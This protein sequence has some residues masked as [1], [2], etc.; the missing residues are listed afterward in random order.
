MPPDPLIAAYEGFYRTGE[1]TR[2]ALALSELM[3]HP[4]RFLRR[5]AFACDE[6]VGQ[7]GGL[8]TSYF[9]STGAVDAHRPGTILRTR[10]MH[11]TTSFHLRLHT[12]P[13]GKPVNSYV[14]TQAYYVPMLPATAATT[15]AGLAWTP[16]GLSTQ[17][18][19]TVQLSGCSFLWRQNGGTLECAHLQPTGGLDG[20]ALQTQLS[21]NAGGIYGRTSYGEGRVV[22]LVGIRKG[23]DWRIYAQ[24]CRVLSSDIL[25]VHRIL[26][27]E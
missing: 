2:P 18:M 3:T 14:P 8:F 22:T 9:Y 15:Y 16:L 1:L 27:P 26:P 17:L 21:G 25:S 5:Y 7:P 13:L 20:N 6:I 23:S 12:P 19:V 10:H 24:K 4:R 11:A